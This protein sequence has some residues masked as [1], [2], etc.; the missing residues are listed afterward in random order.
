MSDGCPVCNWSGEVAHTHD[1][2]HQYYTHVIVNNG[3]VFKGKTCSERTRPKRGLIEQLR[4][5]I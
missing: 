4:R 1:Y 3:E 2:T 5:H